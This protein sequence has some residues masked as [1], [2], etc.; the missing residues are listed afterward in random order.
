[1]STYVFPG[2]LRLD[3][4]KQASRPPL[5][6]LPMPARLLVPLLQHA[7]SPA[8]ACVAAGER[9]L[10]GKRIGEADGEDSAHV[11]APA[12]GQVLGI[13]THD[14]G[15]PAGQPLPCVELVP[16][17]RQDWQRMPPL[18]AWRTSPPATLAARLRE[19]G[20]VGLGGAV[21]PTDR[22]LAP[23]GFPVHTLIVNGAECE[24]WIACDDALMR[25]RADQVTAGSEL[26]GHLLGASRILLAVEDHMREALEAL[27]DA[28]AGTAIEL[29][30]VPTRY[31]QGGERQL[32]YTL[33]G[34]EVGA[35][36][37]PRQHGVACVNVATAAAAWRAVVLGEP[38]VSRVVSVAGRGVAGPCSLEVP[39]GTL[40]ADLVEAAGGYT[41]AAQRL[42]LGGPMMGQ[43]LASDQVPVGKSGNCVL[44][45]AA[46]E[47]R[48]RG[49]ELPCIR[50]GECARVCPAR[51]LP[52]QLDAAI[53][54]GDWVATSRLGLADCIE[55]GLC[56]YVCPSQ[57]PLVERFRF[58][59][60]ERAWQAQEA[61]R[62]RRSRVLF[63]ARQARLVREQAAREA[64]LRAR[65]AALRDDDDAP[66]GRP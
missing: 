36:T 15:H 4:R 24:P 45:L 16:D 32:V 61:E 23:D 2:G 26:L 35:G 37:T 66:A 59:K 7:G 48:A 60:G 10:A 8:R 50:C 51:L 41:P 28:A 46:D 14:I 6:C 22:K 29:V 25:A 53:R 49:P 57:I 62:A 1:M 39:L 40:V 17:G 31:P 43:S 64:R 54:A 21:F 18:P 47:L 42:V 19:A 44:V 13:V 33:T 11:H 3:P 12:S 55:C 9:V 30:A 52:Q 58:G 34:I 27:T 65:E 38:L 5:R 56:A 20:V 63:E